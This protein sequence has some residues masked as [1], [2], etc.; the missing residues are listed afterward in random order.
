MQ[1]VPNPSRQITKRF[2]LLGAVG[3]VWQIDDEIALKFPRHSPSD[4]FVHE[5]DIYDTFDRHH[6]PCPHVLQSFYRTEICL[7]LQY[8]PGGSLLD[9]LQSNQTR[10]KH[11]VISVN[12]LEDRR[13][14]ERWTTELCAASAWLETLG[15][16]HG[17]L[18]PANMLLGKQDHLKLAD[19]DSVARIGDTALGS[20]PPWARLRPESA[21]GGFGLYGPETEQF[22]IGSV[23]YYMTR[24]FEPYE[25]PEQSDWP[26]GV[27][28]D[29]WKRQK[30]PEVR[31][32]D[33]LEGLT[34]SCWRGSFASLRLLQEAA[35]RLSGS[36]D[37]AVAVDWSAERR[38]DMGEKCKALLE[39]ATQSQE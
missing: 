37:V 21:S 15:L 5:K 14:I 35:M 29:L 19:F 20:A 39:Q 30:F 33:A 31:P 13:L 10:E 17:D 25:G 23:V 9:R 38:L 4:E 27:A 22:A 7:F 11:K 28:L 3:W 16:V 18:R 34:L 26:A 32:D 12:R 36:E 24:G 8:L 6:Q 2:L 1:R